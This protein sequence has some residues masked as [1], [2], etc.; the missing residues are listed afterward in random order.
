MRRP[1]ARTTWSRIIPTCSGMACMG[2]R[3]C[4]RSWGTG[5][6]TVQRQKTP[7]G[8]VEV[9][10]TWSGGR[11]GIYREDEKYRG[12]AKGEKGEAPVGSYDG[13]EP[14]VAAI[15]KFF[16]TGV[17]PVPPQETIEIMAFMEAADESKNQGG[18]PVKIKVAS[19]A[20]SG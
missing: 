9:V 17:A 8:K 18:A 19:P 13:Y 6:Q 4:S 5:C 3:A 10:G 12:L 20:G 15:M 14:L 1:I 11:K 2:W 16:Q 7:D